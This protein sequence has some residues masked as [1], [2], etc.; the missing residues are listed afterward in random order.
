MKNKVVHLT[1][2][3]LAVAGICGLAIGSVN[4]VTAPIIAIQDEEKLMQGYSEV[5]PGAGEYIPQ[6]YVGADSMITGTVIAANDG[7]TVGVIYVVESKGY[8]GKVGLL[9][10]FDMG[11][12]S[13]TGLKILSQSETPGLGGNCVK[14]WFMDR[15]AGKTAARELK[16]V[17]T[18]TSAEDEVQAI[19]AS[20]ITSTAVVAGV[21]AARADFAANYINR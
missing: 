6:E 16:L 19:T 20:T 9:V 17:K 2:F 14:P 11:T 8:G 4:G 18:E 5:Y 15:F 13:T 21:N 10:G 3:L 1:V 12:G 7:K